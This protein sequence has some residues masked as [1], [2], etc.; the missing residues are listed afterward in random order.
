MREGKETRF[1]QF[2]IGLL[3]VWTVDPSQEDIDE[4]FERIRI[5][6]AQRMADRYFDKRPGIDAVTLAYVYLGE[7][8]P[9]D[10][11][12]DGEQD[13]LHRLAFD[14]VSLVAACHYLGFCI[15]RHDWRKYFYE[16][17]VPTNGKMEVRLR[18]DIFEDATRG[19]FSWREFTLVC[20]VYAAL[21]N[22]SYRAVSYQW[23][24]SLAAG[25][26]SINRKT[27]Q[28]SEQNART[29]LKRLERRGMFSTYCPN[30]R[31]RYYGIKKFEALKSAVDG[32]KAKKSKFA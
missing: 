20:A 30:Q 31:H 2:P 8:G 22:D 28:M 1:I 14:D 17:E 19:E 11:W 4:V 29:A 7:W 18:R 13:E 15:F 25:Y 5:F 27:P 21:G 6:A 32:S 23:I 24:R 12:K 26:S 9:V 3:Q 10:E 16:L